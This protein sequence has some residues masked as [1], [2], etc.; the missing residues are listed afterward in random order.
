MN[1]INFKKFKYRLI[2]IIS[3]KIAAIILSADF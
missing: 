3:P 2:I 1:Q